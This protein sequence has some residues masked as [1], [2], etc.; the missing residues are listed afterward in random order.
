MN[1]K[2][3]PYS[4]HPGFAH[5]S[6]MLAN[7]E[8]RTGRSMSQWIAFLKRS[9]AS[10]PEEC[11]AALKGEKLGASSIGLIIDHMAGKT[12]DSYDPHAMVGALFKGPKATLVPVYDSIL[13][14]VLNM[15]AD[16]NVCPC[17]TIVPFYRKHVFAQVKPSTKSRLDLGLA[18]GSLKSSERNSKALIDTGGLAKKDRITHRLEL[19]VPADFND[20]AKDWLQRAY[21]ADSQ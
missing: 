15:G 8:K 9:K 12:P 17:A 20:F 7:L 19:S 10:T 14:F 1:S 5:W 13:H 21:N 6:A 18:L 11:R 16:V 2:F 3:A 4:L